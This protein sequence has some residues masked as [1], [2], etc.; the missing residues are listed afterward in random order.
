[1]KVSEGEMEQSEAHNEAFQKYGKDMQE[2]GYSED[3][4]KEILHNALK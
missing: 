4:V 1:M 3:Q 2:L